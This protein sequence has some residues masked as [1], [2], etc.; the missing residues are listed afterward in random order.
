MKI[1]PISWTEG[2]GWQ[3]D[4]LAKDAALVLFFAAPSALAW[5]PVYEDLRRMYPKARIAGCSTGGEIAGEDVQDE[6]ISAIALCF[7]SSTVQLALE[8]IADPSQS[9]AVGEALAASLPVKGLRSVFLLADGLRTNGTALVA[10]LRTVLPEQV[11]V[12][13]GLAGDGPDFRQT[14]VGADCPPAEG[15]IAAIGFYGE[16]L[17]IGWGSY[18][19][20][21]R[22]GPER[23]ITRSSTNVLYELDAEPALSLY[24]RYLG[25]E[26]ARLPGSALLFPLT[27]WP[28]G[29]ETSAI[30]RT[31]IAID[32][33]AQSLTFA[34]D[35][36]QGYSAQL[37][38]GHFD[39][40]VEGA[41]RAGTQAAQPEK[42]C[43]GL[44]VSC[45]GR[46]LLLG[47]RV[48]DEV[49][50]VAAAL[51]P[52]TITAGFY[53]YGEIAPHEFTG[54]CELHNQ[55]MTVTTISEL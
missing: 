23:T 20:W 14:F 3:W 39:E 47:Q 5:V 13:G 31:I 8:P 29:E 15:L 21:E 46:K 6:S 19:G 52:Q 35:V 45:I 28:R 36:P 4:P 1:F 17:Q 40:L 25:E 54:R 22:F 10:G 24:K 44:L 7:E 53:S 33:K 43:L 49:E 37:M 9:H 2:T 55:T 32:E 42:A 34:G 48:S 12:T 26:A 27:V 51:G 38:R 16:R 30:V 11:L 18:G 41:S 50:A